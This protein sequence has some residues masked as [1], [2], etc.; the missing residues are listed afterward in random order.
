MEKKRVADKGKPGKTKINSAGAKRMKLD[1]SVRG[2][3]M[4]SMK[5]IIITTRI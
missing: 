3:S 1:P 5:R 4:R 2:S